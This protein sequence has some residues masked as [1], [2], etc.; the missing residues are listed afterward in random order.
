MYLGPKPSQIDATVW[1]I[2]TSSSDG[3]SGRTG[4]ATS[5]GV[6]TAQRLRDRDRLLP[7]L[8]LE[9]VEHRDLRAAGDVVDV[10]DREPHPHLLADRQRRRE[11]QLVQP[12]VQAE[13]D[14]VQVEQVVREPRRERQ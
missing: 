13:R 12:V 6:D 3:T 9:R 5:A 2:C 10:L 8:D 1:R 14:A 4:A 11:A 7:A